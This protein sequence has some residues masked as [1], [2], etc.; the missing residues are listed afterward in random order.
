[1]NIFNKLKKFIISFLDPK[2]RLDEGKKSE[3]KIEKIDNF[4]DSLQ[5]N[6]QNHFYKNEILKEIDKNPN[7]IDTLSYSRLVQLNQL[8]SEKIAELENKLKIIE[9]K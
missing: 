2:K 1:M 7:L 3:I 5:K 8:Y 4:I 9:N 6:T